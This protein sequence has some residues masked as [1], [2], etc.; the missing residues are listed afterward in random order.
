MNLLELKE[1]IDQILATN[2]Q[3]AELTVCIPNNK[4]GILG[5]TPV[6]GINGIWPGIDWD[7]GKAIIYPVE[8]MQIMP[9]KEWALANQ[10]HPETEPPVSDAIA[11]KKWCDSGRVWFWDNNKQHTHT[12][13]ELY[14]LFKLEQSK[15]VRY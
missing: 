9:I 12:D 5:G 8:K 2:P 15:N 14:K 6:T 1:R 11:F 13:E 4:P 3:A 10:Q 7:N